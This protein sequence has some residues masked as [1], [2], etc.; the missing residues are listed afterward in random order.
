[1]RTVI[2]R[3]AQPTGLRSGLALFILRVLVGGR[4]AG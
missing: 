3:A 1:M 4:P 2:R